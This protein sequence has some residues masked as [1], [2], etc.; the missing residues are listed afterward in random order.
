MAIKVLLVLDVAISSWL[1][2]YAVQR[3]VGVT[4]SANGCIYVVNVPAI[5]YGLA[6][7]VLVTC[8]SLLISSHKFVRLFGIS[9]VGALS[10]A[11]WSYLQAFYSVWCFFAA[12][13][14]FMIYFHMT[15]A[16]EA[17]K[18]E[19]RKTAARAE[20]AVRNQ[21]KGFK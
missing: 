4:P 5:P 20:K 3:P 12:I 14:S 19:A 9:M 17:V 10:L 18:R 21:V 15:G 13:L 1:F 7:Y 8:V 16:G 11:L 2:I 6:A